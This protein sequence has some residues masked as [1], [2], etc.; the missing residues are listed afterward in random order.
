MSIEIS[1][2]KVYLCN[3]LIYEAKY[4]IKS[5]IEINDR[6]ILLIDSPLKSKYNENV[7]CIDVY[8]KIVWSVPKVTHIYEDTPYDL[9]KLLDDMRLEACNCDSHT[10][11]INI[12]SGEIINRRFVK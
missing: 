11:I 10:Y 7:V 9:I 4:S 2:N 12:E 3:N 6:I 5:F 8:G 1:N